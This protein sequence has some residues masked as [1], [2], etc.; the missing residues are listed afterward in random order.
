M[1][2]ERQ[3]P[4]LDLYGFWTLGSNGYRSQH[5]GNL[6]L[7]SA[8]AQCRVESR[9]TAL[10]TR[11]I[12]NDGEVY[13]VPT[14]A[15]SNPDEIAIADY[16]TDD[17]TRIWVYVTP[18]EGFFAYVKDDDEYVTFD[19]TDWVAAMPSEYTAPVTSRDQKTTNYT[20]VA[21]DF[22]GYT[23]L[24]MNSGSAL[25]LTLAAGLTPT[26]SL[27]VVQGGAGAVTVAPDTGVTLI[28][29]GTVTA[30]QYAL[31]SVIPWGTNTYLLKGEVS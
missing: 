27:H 29:D 30:A 7:L 2:G 9:T 24:N 5:S 3:L 14:G 23:I 12:G 16:D 6:R 8:L 25:T 10:P 11:A 28:G 18:Q 31:F 22:D 20:T 21:G 19:G 17:T 4:G 15:G 26:E 1:A 13:I